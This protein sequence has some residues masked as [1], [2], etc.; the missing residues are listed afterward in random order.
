MV[1]SV[2]SVIEWD[3]CLGLTL[4]PLL[5]LRASTTFSISI[6]MALSTLPDDSFLCDFC[7]CSFNELLLSPA[8]FPHIGHTFIVGL[9]CC[10]SMETFPCSFLSSSTSIFAKPSFG[11]ARRWTRF[12]V[13]HAFCKVKFLENNYLSRTSYYDRKEHYYKNW[14]YLLSIKYARTTVALRLLPSKQW[15]R[16]FPPISSTSSM[17]WCASAKRSSMF[18]SSSSFICLQTS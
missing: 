8:F 13:F 10:H 12:R 6:D 3:W 18:A 2:Y 1:S 11:W 14:P 9:R 5:I 4:P 16:T 17:K 7:K 15:T